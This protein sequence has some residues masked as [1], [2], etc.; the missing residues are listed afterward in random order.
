VTP[1]DDL[2]GATRPKLVG[3]RVQRLEDPR[4]LTGA[5]AYTADHK[6]DRLLH[7]ALLRSDQPHARIRSIDLAR[8]RALPG[9]VAAFT[10]EDLAAIVGPIRATSRMRDYYATPLWPLARDKVRHVGEAVVAVVAE[11]RYLAEDAL[12]AVDLVLAPLPAPVDA[13][14]AARDDAPLLHEETSSNV[15]AS[16]QFARGKVAE[17]MAEAAVTVGGRFRFRRKSPL[18]LENRASV[19]TWDRG[20]RALTLY[21]ST[22]IPGIIHDVLVESLGIPGNRLRVVAPDVGGGFGGKTSLYPEETLVCALARHLSRPVKW[23]GDRMEDLLSTYQ[24]FDEIVDAELGVAADGAILG[25]RADVIGDVGAYS[26]YPWTAAIEPVQV[27]SFLP[28]PYRIANY[29]ARARAVATSKA[30]GGA[31][32]GVGRPISAFVMERLIDMA[33]RK[34]AIDPREMRRRNLVGDGEFP[35]KV[36]SGLVWDRSDFQGGLARACDTVGYDALR[37]NQ[38]KA[39]AD[40]RWMGIGLASYAELTG[41]GSRISVAPGMPIN[42]GTETAAIEID[43]TGAVT[44]RF[45]VTSQGQG[46]HTTLAQIIADELGARFEDI[47]VI[48]GDTAGLAHSTGTYASRAAVLAGGAATLAARAVR[49]KVVRC[50]AHLFEAAPEDIATGGGTVSVAGTDKSMTFE[51]LARAVYSHMGRVPKEIRD[52]IGNLEATKVYDPFFGTATS[53][54]HVAV[55]EI[56]PETYRVRILRYLVVEDSGRIINPLI[57]DGQAHGGVAQGI[58]AAL[59]EEI[60]HDENG[61]ML[62]ASLVDYVVPLAGDVPPM[63][64]VHLE[65]VSPSTLG[66]FRG[67]G[68]G[69]TIGAP[70]AIANAIADALS[71]LGIEIF[72][73]PVTPERLYRLITE[74]KRKMAG[75]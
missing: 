8:A 50:A 38:V 11:S 22:Q 48:I 71:P 35:Y 13:E 42:T 43:A 70:A 19:A 44:A 15:L 4:L 6:F 55:V 47:Q 29:E 18:A 60:V 17:A 12:E 65:T 63:E 26:V 52:E 72:E 37:A 58:G 73:L 56:D 30:T 23:T 10:G 74:A 69:G 21:S 59:F 3:A 53:A 64:V 25:L 39:R 49:E 57:A 27:V 54:T 5:G 68:E 40:G 51:E 1:P 46:L 7:V 32:R 66:G 34:L 28:G 75:R 61:Q 45:G 16:R 36:A 67:L 20:Q 31:F 9:V 2:T 41:L 62:T 24:A 14:R 33:S